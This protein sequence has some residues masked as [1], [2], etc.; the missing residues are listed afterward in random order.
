MIITYNWFDQYQ[1][2]GFGDFLSSLSSQ[3]RF[4]KGSSAYTDPLVSDIEY[5]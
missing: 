4:I 3:H 5:T 1:I 2:I